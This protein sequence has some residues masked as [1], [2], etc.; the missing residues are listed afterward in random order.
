VTGRNEKLE[1]NPE[2][3][4]KEPFGEGWLVRVKLADPAQVQG[5]MDGAAYRKFMASV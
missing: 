1:K 4:N 3:V 5:L 2:L